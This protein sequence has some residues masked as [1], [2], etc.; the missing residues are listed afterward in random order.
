[1][2]FAR[3]YQQS[4]VAPDFEVA[5]LIRQ[6]GTKTGVDTPISEPAQTQPSVTPDV[7]TESLEPSDTPSPQRITEIP[8]LSPL[9]PKETWNRLSTAFGVLLSEMATY[10]AELPEGHLDAIF[11]RAANR[12]ITTWTDPENPHSIVINFCE[13]MYS[14]SDESQL[15]LTGTDTLTIEVSGCRL[16]QI[17][18]EI[19]SENES[20]PAGYPCRYHEKMAKKIAEIT[21]L[22]ISVNA[23]STGCM[24]QIELGS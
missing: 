4:G 1:M 12:E 5:G 21:G 14:C 13:M 11:D 19:A 8:E 24:V 7:S 22:N 3:R 16:L 10:G 6:D 20:Y 9:N 17:G 18:R 2:Q 23:S 15:P